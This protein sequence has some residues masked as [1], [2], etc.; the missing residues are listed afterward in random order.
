[1]IEVKR[2]TQLSWRKFL[3]TEAGIEAMLYLR[4]NIP[5]VAKSDAH[6]IAFD[7]GKA[8]G[9]KDCLNAISELIAAPEEKPERLENL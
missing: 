7:A 1:M 4:E 6:G 2:T 5:N 3:A 8:Q 9:W